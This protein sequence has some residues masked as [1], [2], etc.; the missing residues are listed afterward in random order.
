MNLVKRILSVAFSGLLVLGVLG[1]VAV[2]GSSVAHADVV[3]DEAR[4]VQR[5]N[6]DR[7]SVGAP[8]LMVSARLVEIA[9]SWSRLLGERSVSLTECLLAHNQ[10]LLEVLRPAS[11]A[12][13]N[14]GCG[15]ADA[16]ALHNAFISSPHHRSNM[17]LR[18][19]RSFPYRSW[20]RSRRRSFLPRSC[21]RSL[22]LLGRCQRN[23]SPL[24]R[25]AQ[26]SLQGCRQQRLLRRSSLAHVLEVRARAPFL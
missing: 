16:D 3:L 12:A 21:Q 14:V 9:R 18:R 23:R 10:N 7:A 26:R 19:P 17:R 4:F 15:D 20:C 5:M 2:L 11:K 8:P 24:K 1:G 13:E 22:V 25:Q 6:A